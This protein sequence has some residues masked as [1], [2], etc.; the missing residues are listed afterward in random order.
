MSDEPT[1]TTIDESPAGFT[2]LGAVREAHAALMSRYRESDVPPAH[3]ADDIVTFIHNG[4]RT[5]ALLDNDD[6]ISEL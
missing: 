6:D 5:G 3:F 2:S 4:K 1:T